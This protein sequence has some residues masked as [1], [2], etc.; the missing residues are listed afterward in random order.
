MGSLPGESKLGMLLC[1]SQFLLDV[2]KARLTM[3]YYYLLLVIRSFT[4]ACCSLH[5]VTNSKPEA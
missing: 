2:S 1:P 4:C 5:L 3:T